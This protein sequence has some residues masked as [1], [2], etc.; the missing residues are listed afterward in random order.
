MLLL[1]VLIQYST[2]SDAGF[3]NA[4]A[5]NGGRRREG[6]D[7]AA[8]RVLRGGDGHAA[9]RRGPPRGAPTQSRPV[10]RRRRRGSP[11]IFSLFS[12]VTSAS[13]SSSYCSLSMLSHIVFVFLIVLFS[14]MHHFNLFDTIFYRIQLNSPCRKLFT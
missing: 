9:R 12:P 8:P 3:P 14:P 6:G 1:L 5:G 13:C 10:V 4:Y 7:D 11:L 2:H